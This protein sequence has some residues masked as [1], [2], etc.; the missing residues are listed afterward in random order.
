MRA[1]ASQTLVAEMKK[2]NL[3]TPALALLCGLAL[4][5]QSTG[6]TAQVAV[7]AER[8]HTWNFTPYGP[9]LN[10]DLLWNAADGWFY[11]TCQYGGA[12]DR[13]LIFRMRPTGEMEPLVHFTG[14]GVGSN[15]AGPRGQ[16]ALGADGCLYGTTSAG[17]SN[18]CG[19]VFKVTPGGVLTT[20]VHFTGNGA[21]NKG[22]SPMAGLTLG[23]D[24]SFYGTTV[25]GGGYGTLFKMTPAGVLTTLLT[26]TGN[27]TSNK[28]SYPYSSL[29]LGTDGHFYGTTY[30]G[31][32]SNCGTVFKVT[33][34]GVLT[35]LVHFTG[36]GASNKGERPYTGLEPAG[37]G[38]FYGTTYEGGSHDRGTI[39]HINPAGVLTTLVQFTTDPVHGWGP[40]GNLTLAA[41]GHLYGTTVGGGT[42]GRGTAFQMTPAGVLTTLVHFS[43]DSGASK[44]A[45]PVGRLN[46]GG[47]GNFY[48][49]TENGGEQGEGTAFKMTP[50][51]ELTTLVEFAHLGITSAGATPWAN[52][53][54]GADGHVYGMTYQ[55]GTAGHGT[56]FKMSPAGVMTKLVD[57]SNNGPTNKGSLPYGGLMRASDGHF[58]GCTS[59]GGAWGYGTAFR[60]TPEGVLT[61]LVEFSNNG[62]SNR[63]NSPRD[64]LVEGPDGALYGTTYAGGLGYGTVFR[65]TREGVL[66][67][68]VEFSNNGASN[69]GSSPDAGL[70]L[71]TDGNFYGTTY[72]GG[73]YNHGTVFR[74]TPAGVLTT[75]VD[76]T[77]YG[78]SNK[79]SRPLGGLVQGP[80]GSL[81]GITHQGG[82][83]G[84]TA[85]PGTVFKM[86]LA[87]ALT[88]LVTF[89]NDG[90]DHRGTYPVGRLVLAA[91]GN[92]YGQTSQGGISGKGTVFRMTPAGEHTTLLEFAGV[93]LGAESGST[94][95]G[96]LV[97]DSTGRKLYG[98]T[99]SGGG[100]GGI[101]FRLDV[102]MPEIT[103]SGNGADVAC[104]DMIPAVTDHTDFGS[105]LQT[106]GS[107]QH[108]YVIANT[109]T[110]ALSLN[111][112]PVVEISGPH[113]AD[114]SLTG[115]PATMVEAAGQTI[116]T[117]TF[118]PSAGGLRQATVSIASTD[119]DENPFTFAIQGRGRTAVELFGE[120]MESA[121]LS[122]P[123]AAM[124]TAPQ[125][126]GVMN[127]LKYAF[128]MNASAPDVRVLT[129]ITGTA[130]LPV[131]SSP[132]SGQVRVEYLRRLGSGLIYT[133]KKSTTLVAGSWQTLLSS[134]QISPL[135][136][137]WE[138]VVHVESVAGEPGRCFISVEVSLP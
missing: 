54:E 80:D 53:V 1:N 60:L 119:A 118:A 63:G 47:D 35:T 77:N 12:S 71:A 82:T 56:I 101:I 69:R 2:M 132:A 108:A 73:P 100:G 9:E 22:Q 83:A 68:L 48:A 75:L 99:S 24:G 29:T 125:E 46:L 93:G 105:V 7:T 14:S 115:A 112:T 3:N 102:P 122:G 86:T 34:E 51:G 10:N 30:A 6:A 61:T 97:A 110:M 120:A 137:D 114:F 106:V 74:M 78:L 65:L 72:A 111:G 76:F 41:D 128:N 89:S 121:G 25:N 58:Y 18:N 55:G 57:F 59:R 32:S 42:H 37:D 124:D 87:G 23:P 133:P 95:R 50:A 96:G 94:P 52:L 11:G 20:L 5:L 13:G 38:G 43:G 49:M 109:G 138:R 131:V 104:G 113:A 85:G 26:F 107:R 15:G 39:F 8:L 19:T 103:L 70:V 4:L 84:Q 27:G 88:T 91:D 134:P 79:G 127:L 64:R 116:F 33:P 28:G 21:S 90:L 17:G 40:R 123:G 136:A 36:N 98:M 45:S 66:T 129:P 67:T 130:G 135:N 44:G 117:L 16:L 126:D 81:Y 92:F 62:A 31:G